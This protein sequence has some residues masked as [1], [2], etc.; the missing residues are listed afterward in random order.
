MAIT[1][2]TVAYEFSH[3]RTPRGRGS[4]A[5]AAVRNPDTKDIIWSP[6]MTYAEAKKH[7]AKIAA[8]RGIS[9][10]YVQS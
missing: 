3:G 2:N 1:F 7:A 8:E 5:F 10:L 6:S 9:T 4:W